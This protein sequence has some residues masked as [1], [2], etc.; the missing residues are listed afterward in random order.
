MKKVAAIAICCSMALAACAVREPP[1]GGP[2]DKEPPEIIQTIPAADSSGLEGDISFTIVFNE[3]I[4]SQS[5]KD[6]IIFYPGFPFED[7]DVSDSELKISFR[8]HLPDTTISLYLKK[9]YKDYHGVE[10]ERGAVFY[11][12]TA[13]SFEKGVI[14]G[15]V[16]FKGKTDRKGIVRI[17]PPTPDTLEV[18]SRME[19]RTVPVDKDGNFIFRHLPTDSAA[20]LVWA[21]IDDNDDGNFSRQREFSLVYPDT[22]YLGGRVTSRSDIIMDIID[23]DEPGQ[24][25]GE[26]VNETEYEVIPSI[27]A[28]PVDQSEK[29]Y[30]SVAD[31]TG[32]Y[33]IRGVKPGDYIISAFLD[34]SGDSTISSC[35]D[36]RDSTSTIGEPGIILPDTLSLKPGEARELE[37]I[38]IK[39]DSGGE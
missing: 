10:S 37:P 28:S 29:E 24:L 14:S 12:A 6:R 22:I 21:F 7:I 38:I 9:G 30:Y 5:F 26:I 19:R 11:Y 25:E 31:S 8:E 23:P 1:S 17:A 39:D 33:L 2:E 36:P 15:S 27:L 13:D 35:M 20:L 4:D 16:T 34:I 32:K 18:F 3:K